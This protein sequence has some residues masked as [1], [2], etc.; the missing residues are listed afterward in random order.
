MTQAEALDLLPY[1]TDEERAELDALLWD[2]GPAPLR[3]QEGPQSA[4]V[5]SDADIVVYGGSAGG[6]KS[7]ALLAT[8]VIRGHTDNAGFG[9]TIFRR[10][11]PDITAEGGLWDEAADLY[12]PL[13]ASSIE[14]PLEVTFPSGARVRFAHMQ[15]VKDRFRWKGAQIPY[16]G[17]DQLEEFEADQF[18][19]LTSR[20]RSTCGVTPYI[21]A[22]CN[23][24]PDS[25]VKGFLA[26]WVDDQHPDYP[27]PAGELRWFTRDGDDLV[28]VDADWRD[29]DGQPATSLT[30]I[31]ATIYDNP[32]LLAANPQYLTRLRSLPM[33]DRARLLDGD[34]NARYAGGMFKREWFKVV[35]QAPA[36]L[37]MVARSWDE[38]ATADA[39]DWTVGA[40]VGHAAGVWYVLDLVREQASAAGV[41]KLMDQAAAMDGWQVPIVLQ[42]EPGSS[43]KARIEGHRARL[44]GYTVQAAPP[45]GNKI[46]RA[47]PLASAAE[48]GNVVLVAGPW[49]GA[50]L[51][52][53]VGFPGGKNDDQI[54]AVSWAVLMLSHSEG[55]KAPG[56]PAG[57]GLLGSRSRPDAG[58][59]RYG[60]TAG[61]GARYGDK[62][63]TQPRMGTGIGSAKGRG[64]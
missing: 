60:Q 31:P 28:W 61:A 56:V 1:L 34:W 43:G 30:Y 58:P 26:P 9:A 49:N 35:D 20:N 46:V 59:K 52:E 24:D 17:F 41:D 33:V 42:Q 47:K 55:Q 37:D 8:P 5:E 25:W 21:R 40:L 36:D 32:A 48:A 23:P 18:W 39:G 22:T 16:I 45:T 54:D 4:F 38:A 50:F 57:A 51:N 53:A 6:G 64:R 29:P 62:G 63:G 14:S 44:K 19:Y 27:A 2:I 3:P 13:G 15:H 12:V 7:W 11:Y 10:T